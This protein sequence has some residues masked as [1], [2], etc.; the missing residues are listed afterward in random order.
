MDGGGK[1]LYGS[2]RP[3]GERHIRS[4]AGGGGIGWGEV[5]WKDMMGARRKDVP[6][7]KANECGSQRK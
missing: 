5:E 3:R 7:Y 1:L 6:A 2:E 4:K